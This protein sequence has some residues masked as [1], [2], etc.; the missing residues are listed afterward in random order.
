MILT[1]L[2]SSTIFFPFAILAMTAEGVA[3][4]QATP[5]PGP[6]VPSNQFELYA[7]GEGFGGLPVFYWNGLA[8]LGNASL[9][10]D[11][12]A[13]TVI[14]SRSSSDSTTMVGSPIIQPGQGSP[15]PSWS[16][17]TYYI[18]ADGSATHQTG[19]NSA[20]T[21]DGSDS[22]ITDGFVFYGGTAAWEADNGQ[23]ET[24]WYAVPFEDTEIW[25]LNW[26]QA[27]DAADDKVGVS[28][29][30]V[31]PSM[32]PPNPPHTGVPSNSHSEAK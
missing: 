20:D 14:F 5:P 7:Y 29:R 31:M 23:L 25:M 1:K 24:M 21:S 16:N 4:N 6:G 22:I 19:F 17:V 18:P 30:T 26:D 15:S 27:G 12:E 32:P 13:A 3:Q 8:Y 28:L 9:A 2:P 11:T 10:N